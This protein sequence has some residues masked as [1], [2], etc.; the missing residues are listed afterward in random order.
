MQ[1]LIGV[2]VGLLFVVSLFVGFGMGLQSI[3]Q[4]CTQ[5]YRFVH[6]GKQYQCFPLEDAKEL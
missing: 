1:F 2:A 4:D 5:F 3:D 6:Y